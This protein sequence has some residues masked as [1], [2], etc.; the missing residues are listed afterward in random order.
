[1]TREEKKY[2]FCGLT[3]IAVD[4]AGGLV[5]VDIFK[6]A[7]S[8]LHLKK[9]TLRGFGKFALKLGVF[10]I[11]YELTG[12]GA[13]PFIEMLFGIDKKKVPEVADSLREKMVNAASSKIDKFVYGDGV[14]ADADDADD[15]AD[16]SE[17]AEEDVEDAEENEEE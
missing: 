7:T 17:D 12:K 8:N 9:G 2:L 11:G 13:D 16:I 14:D 6:K 10:D 1:M 3:E 4:V 15:N 5:A